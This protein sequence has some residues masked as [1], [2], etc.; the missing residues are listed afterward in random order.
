LGS[1]F[2]GAGKHIRVATYIDFWNSTP[3]PFWLCEWL[4]VHEKTKVN[5]TVICE[6]VNAA[7]SGIVNQLLELH[8]VTPLSPQHLV[9]ITPTSR[10]AFASPLAKVISNH[11]GPFMI[12]SQKIFCFSLGAI[13]TGKYPMQKIKMNKAM[14]QNANFFITPPSNLNGY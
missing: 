11:N 3:T 6:R 10:Q 4:A 14:N 7:I 12:F 9:G 1:E 13:L 5:F 8:F 2:S